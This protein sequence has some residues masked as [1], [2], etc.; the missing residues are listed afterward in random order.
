MEPSVVFDDL[1]ALQ[2]RPGYIPEGAP[3]EI[4]RARD[5]PPTT[6]APSSP[7]PRTSVWLPRS[8]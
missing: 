2:E 8:G 3:G 6:C 1:R 4:G 5:I 7:P